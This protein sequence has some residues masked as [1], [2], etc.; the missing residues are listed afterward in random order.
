MASKSPNST[1]AWTS[2]RTTDPHE[3]FGILVAGWTR[4]LA[5]GHP[6]G[7][8]FDRP[9]NGHLDILDPV[10]SRDRPSQAR[11]RRQDHVESVD[12]AGVWQ[13]CPWN[14]VPDVEPV[15]RHRLA[16]ALARHRE[17]EGRGLDLALGHAQASKADG[18]A[19]FPKRSTLLADDVIRRPETILQ[20]IT[21]PSRS[22]VATNT[23]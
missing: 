8:L 19:Q 3:K 16:G 2:R 1:P 7:G 4:T 23:G 17:R 22:S 20:P 5:P 21:R 18:Y 6:R 15:R 10:L 13:S 11:V 9:A 14:A 12:T